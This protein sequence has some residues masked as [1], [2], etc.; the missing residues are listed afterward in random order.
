[1]LHIREGSVKELKCPEPKCQ[2]ML[3]DSEIRKL[4]PKNV[5]LRFSELMLKMAIGEMEDVV[6]CP[7]KNCSTPLILPKGMRYPT[8]V[9]CCFTFCP[10]CWNAPHGLDK[11]LNLM[12]E[13][14]KEGL[15][16]R[17]LK[18]VARHCP[19]CDEVIEKNGGCDHM[20]CTK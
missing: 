18:A 1:M 14:E 17:Y 5:H 13:D 7:R 6:F 4:V 8:C 16:L 15:S 11:C 12:S 3:Q 19:K 10:K 2:E 20:Y 9:R